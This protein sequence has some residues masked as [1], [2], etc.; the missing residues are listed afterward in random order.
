MSAK[1]PR[2]RGGANPFSA[3]RLKSITTEIHKLS[4]QV[5]LCVENINDRLTA[6]GMIELLKP[7]ENKFC[8]NA[9]EILNKA[10]TTLKKSEYTLSATALY[11]KMRNLPWGQSD[12]RQYRLQYRLHKNTNRQKN[13]RQTS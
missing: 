6:L 3:I 5:T 13:R 4:E 11:N 1:F 2:G 7:F 9:C 10:I 8:P 12:L